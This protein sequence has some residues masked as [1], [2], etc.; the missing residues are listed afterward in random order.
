MLAA[1]SESFLAIL[2][3]K[4]QYFLSAGQQRPLFVLFSV[5]MQKE[6]YQLCQAT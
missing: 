3:G 5:H 2:V 4:S 6:S 1:V